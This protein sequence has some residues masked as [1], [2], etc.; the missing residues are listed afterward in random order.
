M[1]SLLYISAK[2]ACHY[3]SKMHPMKETGL[4][5]PCQDTDMLMTSSLVM[6]SIDGHVCGILHLYQSI[7][8]A[9]PPAV[10]KARCIP[11]LFQRHSRKPSS[12]GSMVV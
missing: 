5:L 3:C 10:A 1:H 7:F 12:H 6:I 8:G 11:E 2:L 9:S 4:T